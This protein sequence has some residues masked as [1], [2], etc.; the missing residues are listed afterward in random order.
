MVRVFRHARGIPQY[1]KGH[2]ARMHQIDTLL[3]AHPGV[4]L[5]GNSYRGVS[6]NACIADAPSVADAAL[7]AIGT[8]TASASV[9]ISARSA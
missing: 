4:L 1:V 9:P 2:M 5:A 6:I 3:S 7:R 8:P